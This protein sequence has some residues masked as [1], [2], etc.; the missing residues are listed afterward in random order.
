[1]D[2]GDKKVDR[3]V[4]KTKKSIRNA[5]AELLTIKDINEITIKDIAD[6]ADINRKT[7]YNYYSGVYE[8]VGEIENEI[9]A[10]LSAVIG[11][12]DI[13][14]DMGNTYP[15]F[16]K[17]TAIINND[18]E[19]YS[20]LMKIENNTSLLPKI[21]AA[22]KEKMRMSF[23]QQWPIDDDVLDIMTEFI[24]SGMLSVYRS[25]FNSSRE[26]SIEDV[27]KIVGTLTS[28][29]VNGIFDNPTAY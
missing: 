12:I 7:F 26:R 9:V 4:K 1:M 27:S 13:Q 20:H 8:V 23:S 5:F 3:R 17:L 15:I 14:R 6:V 10:A 21:T 22:L 25:W 19:F 18:L 16:E 29:G 11:E 2:A 24:F 28:S